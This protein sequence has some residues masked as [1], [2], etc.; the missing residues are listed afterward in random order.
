MDLLANYGLLGIF[1]SS[2]L[3]YSIVPFPSEATMLAA[4]LYFKPIPIIAV[5]LLGSTLGSITNYVIGHKGIKRHIEKQSKWYK[6]AKRMFD[7][8]SGW[9]IVI[10]GNFPLIGDP[11]MIIAG[12][13]NMNFFKFLFYSTIGKIIY[14]TTLI[15]IGKGLESIIV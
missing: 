13:F 12:S 4:M 14:F 1:V 3:A 9:S 15:Y 2:L 5:A 8:H 11:L 7:K 6:K 10:F